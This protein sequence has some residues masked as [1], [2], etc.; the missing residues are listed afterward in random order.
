MTQVQLKRDP[1]TGYWTDTSRKGGRLRNVHTPDK[2]VGR[3]CDIHS[4]E[5]SPDKELPLI[6]RT[7]RGICE[8]VC[9]HGIGHPT[10]AQKLY[11]QGLVGLGGKTQGW[12]DAEEVHGCC[13]SCCARWASE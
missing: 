11:W 1:E 10:Y 4:R 8:V 12:A 13:G 3:P 2:C 5:A 6:F 7:D 9:E